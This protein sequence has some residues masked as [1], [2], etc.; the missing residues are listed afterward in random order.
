MNILKQINPKQI[1]LNNI[2][3]TIITNINNYNTYI[4]Y[5]NNYYTNSKIKN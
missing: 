2:T 1:K 5:N 4:K 3:Y